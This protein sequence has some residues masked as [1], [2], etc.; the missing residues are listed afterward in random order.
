MKD[1]GNAIY[2]FG[3][4]VAATVLGI[5]VADYWFGHHELITFLSWA[6]IGGHS[7]ASR[8][9]I[10]VHSG[11]R[12]SP[13]CTRDE[14]RRIAA[15][16]R[17]AAGA[18]R[19]KRLDVGG[20]AR[21]T[22]N[23]SGTGPNHDKGDLIMAGSECIAAN[24]TGTLNPAIKH[25]RVRGAVRSADRATAIYRGRRHRKRRPTR[26]A[27][28]ICRPIRKL[29]NRYCRL[30]FAPNRSSWGSSAAFHSETGQTERKILPA[31]WQ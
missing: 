23:I 7:V 14:A 21:G 12:G 10:F 27:I 6:G 31:H 3:C 25:G 16:N 26:P 15:N 29:F 28:Q 24:V 5:G 20:P 11:S 9:R 8:L 19:P 18:V 30:K 13:Y 1:F 22:Q 2:A 17:Q 4:V